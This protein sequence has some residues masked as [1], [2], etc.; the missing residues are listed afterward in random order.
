MICEHMDDFPGF[1][2]TQRIPGIFLTNSGMNS[3]KT[4]SDEKLYGIDDLS[5]KEYN[6]EKVCVRMHVT[7]IC[8]LPTMEA[9]IN[10][11][12]QAVF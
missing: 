5:E 2:D 8:P 3:A 12:F 11:F 10:E 4:R 6:E 7:V 1:F 9:I